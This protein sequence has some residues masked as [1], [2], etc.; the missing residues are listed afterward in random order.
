[1]EKKKYRSILR[2]SNNQLDVEKDA[3]PE[4][5]NAVETGSNTTKSTASK[6]FTKTSS[7]SFRPTIE[8][9]SSFD[10]TKDS[11]SYLKVDATKSI[12]SIDFYNTNPE[13]PIRRGYY[14]EVVTNVNQ[15]QE[16]ELPGAFK[17]TM[18]IWQVRTERHCP[19]L[20]SLEPPK[21]PYFLAPG[22]RWTCFKEEKQIVI[23]IQTSITGFFI[24][25]YFCF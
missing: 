23:T 20:I 7:R 6:S 19:I 2:S 1:M 16:D 24:A 9:S 3:E 17:R 5:S 18:L 13:P 11:V 8:Y 25:A 4:S 21:K 10:R 15:V 14:S 12:N 22:E